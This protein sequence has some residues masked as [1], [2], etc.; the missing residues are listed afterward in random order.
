[1]NSNFGFVKEL[2]PEMFAY[3]LDVER[4]AKTEPYRIGNPLRHVLERLCA[5]KIIKYNL[6][7]AML[8]KCRNKVPSLYEQLFMLRDKNGFI[9]EMKKLPGNEGLESLPV[10]RVNLEYKNKNNKTVS[11]FF[12]PDRMTEAEKNKYQWADN[13]LRQIGNDFS[14]DLNPFFERVFTKS[15]ENVIY[16]L[17]CL[18]KY[19][20]I[21]YNVDVKAA[22]V[23]DVDKMP[24]G[25]Y[26]ITGCCI[27]DDAEKSM[28][29]REYTANRYE[30]YSCESVGSSVVRQYL[31]SDEREIFF[32]RVPDVY[33]AGGNY[34]SLL[35]KV[36]VISEG[37]QN[38][39]PFYL[40]SYDFRTHASKLNTEFL[41]GLSER[42]R[43]ELC[44]SYAQTM[45]SFH[46]NSVPVY[47][48]FF[49]PQCAYYA[50]ERGKNRGISTAIIKF[51]YAKIF[52]ESVPTVLDPSMTGKIGVEHDE[53]YICEEWNAG[54]SDWS[55]ADIYS[56]GVLFTDILMGRI[57]GYKFS[58][59]LKIAEYN[60]IAELVREMRSRAEN[61]PDIN[62]VCER[63]AEILNPAEKKGR[64]RR[65]FG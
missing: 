14:H 15:Y 18:H 12:A 59:F 60:D 51:E 35:N 5:M 41:S 62:S 19:I 17:E 24:I 38:Q 61:R 39:S 11:R 9:S 32:R 40:V 46:N 1:M 42:E 13:F 33:L 49:T 54:M 43:K 31:R 20:R 22:P 64:F 10:F 53:R 6:K 48:R 58:E 36:T 50:D 27:P 7:D 29:E 2:D 25:N 16:A 44:L 21:Y 47:H 3:L 55:K 65:I 63:L 28:C 26:E 30:E 4:C 34:G 57:G 37:G 56:L 45:S 23:F 52:D 8:G